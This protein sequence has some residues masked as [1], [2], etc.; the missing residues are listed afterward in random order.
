MA[1]PGRGPQDLEIHSQLVNLTLESID[2]SS[3]SAASSLGRARSAFSARAGTDHTSP[4]R[5][6]IS[7]R[8][9]AA[10]QPPAVSPLSKL[11]TSTARR[12]AVHRWTSPDVVRPPLVTSTVIL[13]DF[14]PLVARSTKGAGYERAWFE[15]R[16]VGDT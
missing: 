13:F 11:I 1:Q 15:D 8:A 7:I 4:R 2:L 3:C 5:R 10:P 16:A 9:A 6:L 14:V 12:L